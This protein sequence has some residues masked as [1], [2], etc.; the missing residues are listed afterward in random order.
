MKPR[1]RR[2]LLGSL[3]LLI[4]V[5]LA[6]WVMYS[7]YRSV[8][9]GHAV[10]SLKWSASQVNKLFKTQALKHLE[11]D[12]RLSPQRHLIDAHAAVTV[13]SKEEG[14][15]RFFFLLNDGLKISEVLWQGEPIRFHRLWLLTWVTLP[16]PLKDNEEATLHFKY[17]GNTAGGLMSVSSGYIDSDEILLNVDEFW[18]PCDLQGFYT[19]RVRATLPKSLKLIHTGRLISAGSQ[20][21]TQYMVFEHGRPLGGFA[22]MAVRGPSWER[23]MEDGTR[24]KLYLTEGLQLDAE[25]VL[26]MMAESQRYLKS[27]Y[28]PNGYDTIAMLVSPRMRRGFN[29][30]S[31]QIGLSIRYFRKGDYG[32]QTVA[33]EIAHNWW[34]ATVAEKWLSSGTGGEW[35]VEGFAEFS[36]DIALADRFGKGALEHALLDEFF[37]P[38]RQRSVSEMSVIDNMISEPTARDT[39]YRKGAF[40]TYML[41]EY[42]GEELF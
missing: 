9:E 40:V 25:R 36:C 37:D 39:I 33:H 30:G 8:V 31:S 16:R 26:D 20:G 17:S 35:L 14:K 1:T 42:L 7:R 6:A 29:D 22:L 38:R 2:R 12:V 3:V 41:K 13:A 27:L 10:E 11:L 32:Y 4:M 28:G 18:F 34:G 23:T 21:E 5:S 19:V 24:L 15:R